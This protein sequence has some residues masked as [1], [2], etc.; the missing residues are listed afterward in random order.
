MSK[1]SNLLM[2]GDVNNLDFSSFMAFVPEK[3]K[4]PYGNNC[5]FPHPSFSFPSSFTAFTSFAYKQIQF[6]YNYD[7]SVINNQVLAPFGNKLYREAIIIG[8]IYAR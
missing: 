6:A 8:K 5:S 7:S 3:M 4:L 2:Q 1:L